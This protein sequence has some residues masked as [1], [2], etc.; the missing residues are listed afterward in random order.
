MRNSR[1]GSYY[2]GILK[3]KEFRVYVQENIE[4]EA[5]GIVRNYQAMFAR[6]VD[7]VFLPYSKVE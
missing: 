6:L 7:H 1:R 5:R 4:G 2:Y 3:G